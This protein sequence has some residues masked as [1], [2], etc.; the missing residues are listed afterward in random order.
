[1]TDDRLHLIHILECIEKIERYTS[2]RPGGLTEDEMLYDAVLRNLQTMSESAQRL[3]PNIKDAHPE[4]PWSDIAGFRNIL[5]H[6]YLGTIKPAYVVEV[7]EA[8]L[9]RLRAAVMAEVPD[10]EALKQRRDKR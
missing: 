8:D 9:P 10:W 5:L 4:I 2:Q 6:G 7:V 3:S 1:M